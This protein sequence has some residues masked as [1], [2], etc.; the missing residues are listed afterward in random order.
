M[1]TEACNTSSGKRNKLIT[2]I[3]RREFLK[4]SGVTGGAL[5]LGLHGG[6]TM[7]SPKSRVALLSTEDR[8]SAVAS[9]IKALNINP[10][11]NKDVL[12]KPNF[13]TADLC[14]GSTHNDTLVAL[15]EEAWKMGAKSVSIGERSYPPTREVMEHKGVIP[16]M[17]KLDVT[18]IDFDELDNKDWVAV[19]P[20]DSHW[21]NGFRIARPILEAECLISTCCLKTHRYGGVFTM[22]LKLHV[23][24]VPTHRH[25]YE[26]MTELHGS[27]HQRKMIA[28]I[29]L[30]FQPDLIVLD[31]IEAFVD[32]GPM[33]GKR[34][35]GNVFLASTDRVAT[36]AVGV[37][38]LKLLGSNDQ[39]MTPKIF[40]QEQ[41]ARAVE[42]GLGASS[43]LEIDVLPAD[44]QSREY[45]NRVVEILNKG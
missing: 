28:E 6:L 21:E 8:R 34:A 1:K 18:I 16:L 30:P 40:E 5:L 41:I 33:N 35:Q 43:P 32:G 26:Y 17:K 3:S 42:I 23:G 14:P 36:D 24:V 2:G 7:A 25:G 19:K 29:N 9:S 12:I 45:R 37:A 15:V 20:R 39:I 27:P 44:D 11:K 13:N 38:I 31:G 4:Y 10:C 22:S